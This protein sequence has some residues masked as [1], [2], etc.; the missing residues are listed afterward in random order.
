MS[1]SCDSS[2]RKSGL[3]RTQK[4]YQVFQYLAGKAFSNLLSPLPKNIL[5]LAINSKIMK[6]FMIFGFNFELIFCITF[7][8]LC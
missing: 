4:L 2:Q 3:I 8:L 1:D 7:L 6:Y 5:D